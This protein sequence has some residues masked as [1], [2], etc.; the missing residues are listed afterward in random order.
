MDWAGISID[1]QEIKFGDIVLTDELY[2]TRE[3]LWVLNVKGK[4]CLLNC[5]QLTLD[6]F[7]QSPNDD[8]NFSPIFSFSNSEVKELEQWASRDWRI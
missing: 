4:H 7:T 5:H 6:R 8:A 2:E 3:H 1:Q